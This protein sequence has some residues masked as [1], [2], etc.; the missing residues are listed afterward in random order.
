MFGKRSSFG[1][2]YRGQKGEPPHVQDN[3]FADGVDRENRIAVGHL[4]LNGGRFESPAFGPSENLT[5]LYTRVVPAKD[6]IPR[7][8]TK[9]DKLQSSIARALPS[10]K[11]IKKSLTKLDKLKEEESNSLLELE[12][13]ISLLRHQKEKGITQ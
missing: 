1:K 10:M 8:E 2:F 6:S 4:S 9:R 7:D 11:G 12:R 13:E 5:K 3:L